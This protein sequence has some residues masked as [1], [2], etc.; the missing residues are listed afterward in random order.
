MRPQ[1]LTRTLPHSFSR[2]GIPARPPEPPRIIF[3]RSLRTSSPAPRRM[4]TRPRQE[5]RLPTSWE[6]PKCRACSRIDCPPRPLSGPPLCSISPGHAFCVS[7]VNGTAIVSCKGPEQKYRR[8]LR[9]GAG[10]VGGSIDSR[11]APPRGA[12]GVLEI[13]LRGPLFFTGSWF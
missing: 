13:S 11:L 7:R 3:H 9:W 5:R 10:S 8:D 12:K 2:D 6:E 1:P 4:K